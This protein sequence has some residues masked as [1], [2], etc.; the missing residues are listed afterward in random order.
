M[1]KIL[2]SA[3]ILMMIL[4]CATP[5]FAAKDTLNNEKLSASMDVEA[6]YIRLYTEEEGYTTI[7]GEDGKFSETTDSGLKVELEAEEEKLSL[8]VH[9][10]T[11]EDREAAKWFQM[12]FLGAGNIAPLEFFLADENGVRHELKA[13][14]EITLTG[15]K[16]GQYVV[17]MSS[18]GHKDR[19]PEAVVNGSITFKTT[20]AAHYY[21]VVTPKIGGSGEGESETQKPET[22][23][24]ETEKPETEKP[25]TEKPETE[26]PE[27]TTG[28]PDTG[29]HSHLWLWIGLMGVSFA[30][31]IVV[32]RKMKKA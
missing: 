21:V 13:G 27:N 22:E 32:G 31:M 25:E 10:V 26:K 18:D 19:I 16:E 14:T 8:I 20:E 28:E 29:D 6:K 5:C 15:L 12:H 9:E 30:G 1:K 3:M 11:A 4:C 24:P 23:K 2:S 17:R 7:K